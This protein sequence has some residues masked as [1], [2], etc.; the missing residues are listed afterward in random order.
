MCSA[1]F[2]FV[3]LYSGLIVNHL[4]QDLYVKSWG[5]LRRPLLSNC[6]I[7]YTDHHVYN[8][9]KVRLLNMRPFSDTVDHSKWCVARSQW[10]CI[11]DMNREMS[12]MARG[13]GAICFS[14]AT[15]HQAFDAA[16]ASY[17]TCRD[18]L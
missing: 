12:Q 7:P 18:E 14:N 8:V 13:G 16:I 15:V 17:E 4:N 1:L 5:G 3:D 6:S 2:A 11:A 9:K 10:I